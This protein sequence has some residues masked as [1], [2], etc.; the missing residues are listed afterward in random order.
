MAYVFRSREDGTFRWSA[1]WATL[2][3]WSRR[4]HS[5]YVSGIS[6][7]FM[8]ETLFP[9]QAWNGYLIAHIT[10]RFDVK[11]FNLRWVPHTLDNNQNAEWIA[12]SLELL[13]VLTSQEQ[14]EFD[15]VITSNDPR[16]YF[17]YLHAAVWNPSQD[18]IAEKIKYKIDIKRVWFRSFCLPKESTVDWMYLKV[19]HRIIPFVI[20]L[21]Q[22]LLKVSAHITGEKPWKTSSCIWT[23]QVLIIQ[24]N[25]LNISS[26]LTSVEF[27]IRLIVETWHQVT[28]SSL[29]IWNQNCRALWSGAGRI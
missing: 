8:Q 15:H 28:S 4:K 5:C 29:G 18:E 16:F 25:L 19:L 23:M 2:T 11:K 27:P 3:K 20:P 17:E 6:F 1:I 7:Y 9:F 24:G 13:E 22:I 26:N 12:F 14:N 10:Q 21:W